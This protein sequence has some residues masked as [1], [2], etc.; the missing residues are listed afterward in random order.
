MS[1]QFSMY[2]TFRYME[3]GHGRNRRTVTHEDEAEITLNEFRK[4]R[5]YVLCIVARFYSHSTA[6]I[7]ELRR[8]LADPTYRVPELLDHKAHNVCI[9]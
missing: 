7:R 9:T 8:M 5:N 1:F 4:P 3:E 2:D 6:R